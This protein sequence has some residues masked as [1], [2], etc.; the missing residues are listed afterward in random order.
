MTANAASLFEESGNSAR[1]GVGSLLFEPTSIDRKPARAPT[2]IGSSAGSGGRN[3]FRRWIAIAVTLLLLGG[4]GVLTVNLLKDDNKQQAS[5]AATGNGT[6]DKSV[7][8]LLS[9][10]LNLDIRSLVVSGPLKVDDDFVLSPQTQPLQPVGGQMYYDQTTNLLN[11]YN[12]TQFVA[13]TGGLQSITSTSQQLTITDDGSGNLTVTAATPTTTTTASTSGSTGTVTSSGGTAGRIAKF[14]GA[15]NLE[16]SI[17]S[18]TGT[19]VTLNGDLTVAG[20]LGLGAPLSVVNGGTGAAALAANGVLI[21]NGTSALTSV[22]A[23]GAGQCLLSTVG[24]P[25]FATCPSSSGGGGSTTAFVQGGNSFAATTT[26]GTNDNNAL[27]LE[28]GGTTRVTIAAD[29]S[30]VTLASSTDLVLQ[31]ATAY[32]TNSQGQTD[33]ESFGN[34]ATVSAARGTAIGRSASATGTD[35]TAVGYTATAGTGGIAFGSGATNAGFAHSI[36]L[37]L[38]ATNTAAN[39]VVLGSATANSGQISQLVIGSGV[40]DATPTS[41]TLQGTSGSGSNIAGASVTLAGGQS[42]GSAAGGNLNFQISGTGGAGASLNSLTT[43]ASISGSTGAL[44]LQNKTNSASA[45]QVENAAGTNLLTVSTVHNTSD[46]ITNGNLEQ[47]A[48]G[49][50]ADGSSTISRITSQQYVGSASLQ[51]T[52]TTA[53]GDGVKYPI[54][55]TANTTYTA[56]FYAKLASGSWNGMEFGYSTTGLVAG[57]TFCK[58]NQQVKTGG[59]LTFNCTFTVPNVTIDPAAYFYAKQA[60]GG[61]ARTFY[62]DAFQ[63]IVGSDIGAFYEGKINTGGLIFSGPVAIQNDN[64][65]SSVLQI[66]DSVGQSMFGVDTVNYRVGVGLVRPQATLDVVS[67]STV[68]VLMS[69]AQNASNTADILQVSKN[70]IGGNILTIAHTGATTF[71]NNT[72]SATAFRV[73]NASNV[74]L[75]LVDTTNNLV[76]V[77]ASDTTGT[78]LVLDTKTN[79]GDPTGSN[80]GMYYNS[81]AA[82]FRCYENS[83]WKNCLGMSEN[84]TLFGLNGNGAASS[85]VNMPA[86]ETEF[87]VGVSGINNPANRIR[88]D[89][90]DAEQIR[91]QVNVENAGATNGEIRIQY[92]TDQSSWNYLDNGNTGLGQNVSTTGLKVSSWSTIASGAKGDV[93]LRLTGINGD[94]AADPDFGLIQLQVR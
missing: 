2:P 5:N 77:G 21:G 4:I 79:S 85:W 28:T 38:G 78:L 93:Y 20:S 47:N 33:A 17:L 40:T 34:G 83:N 7:E 75:F 87:M 70:G 51:V 27:E 81:N 48:T 31:G 60:S 63:M 9:G 88:Y 19:I 43:V 36:A 94:A 91:L 73:Q 50:A 44:L 32:F 69:L 72:N 54:Q 25:V 37:G 3:P 45:L 76:T 26:L 86:A 10:N 89:L 23:A 57:E 18:E 68:N 53:A 64:D 65:S 22:T 30:N 55:L 11:Y 71:A 29:G 84:L 46:L 14:T 90:T 58:Q 82:K 24:T 8:D 62:V 49:W 16:N 92:S 56:S 15:Q 6:E 13:L 67:L 39:Q 74:N 1:D 35:S 52:T 41:V 66:Q 12:G 80:G 61:T 42:T 59:W